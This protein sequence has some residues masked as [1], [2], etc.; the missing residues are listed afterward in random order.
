M[1]ASSGKTLVIRGANNSARYARLALVKVIGPN[2]SVTVKRASTR[3][4]VRGANNLIRV[5]KRI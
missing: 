3:V 4:I 1:V 2:N 5:K